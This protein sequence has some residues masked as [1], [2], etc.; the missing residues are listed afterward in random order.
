GIIPQLQWTELESEPSGAVMLSSGSLTAKCHLSKWPPL[1]ILCKI[2][3][4]SS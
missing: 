2:I 4:P 1:T 3:P